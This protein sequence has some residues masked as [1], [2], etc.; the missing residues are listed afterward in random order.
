MPGESLGDVLAGERLRGRTQAEIHVFQVRLEAFFQQSHPLEQFRA[1]Q[2]R[3]PRRRPDR[4]CDGKL[5][6]VGAAVAHA[7]CGAT[8]A[9]NVESG[10]DAVVRSRSQNL[11]G[12]EPGVRANGSAEKSGE[13][14]R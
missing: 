2:G 10:I 11:A 12:G 6:T 9:E 5:R 8:A 14:M 3:G 1:K 13:V 7:P 4:T